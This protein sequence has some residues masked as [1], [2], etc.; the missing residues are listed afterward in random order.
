M[1]DYFKGS[2]TTLSP[3]R[4]AAVSAI[5]SFFCA[6]RD[7]S[8]RPE[9]CSYVVDYGS[10]AFQVASIFGRSDSQFYEDMNERLPRKLAGRTIFVAEIG[11]RRRKPKKF[12]F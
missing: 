1:K 7:R 8:N 12:Q 2:T 6:E 9:D 5:A 11:N 3:A 10:G 4:H